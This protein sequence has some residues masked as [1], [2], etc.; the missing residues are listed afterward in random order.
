MSLGVSGGASEAQG[1]GDLEAA[2]GGARAFLDH[3]EVPRKG[4]WRGRCADA[5]ALGSIPLGEPALQGE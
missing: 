4:K 2:E 1:R 5:T 3:L